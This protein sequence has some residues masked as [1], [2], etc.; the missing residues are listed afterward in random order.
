MAVLWRFAEFELDP[1]NHVLRRG[2]EPVKLA[3][4]PFKLLLLLV[5]RSGAL[6]RRDELRQALWPDG[7][8]VDFEHGLNTCMRQVRAA[9]GDDAEQPRIVETIP[10]VGYRLK[11]PVSRHRTRSYHPSLRTAGWAAGAL[12]AAVIAILILLEARTLL[13]RAAEPTESQTLYMRGRAS[14]DRRTNADTSTA[15]KLFTEAAQA[16]PAL[17]HAQAGIALSYLTHPTGL[18]G[19]AP[20][21]ARE[22]AADAA[23]RAA[24]ISTAPPVVGLAAAE[25]KLA[26]GEWNAAELEFQR[27]IKAAPR[28]AALHE[29]YAVALSLHGRLDEALREAHAARGLDPLSPRMITT[30]ASTLRFARRYEQAIDVAQE[31]LELDPTYGPAL[32]TLGLC[33]QALGQLDRAIEYYER[34][35]QPT[36]NLGHAYAV[37]GRTEDARRLLRLF[38]ARY[39]KQGAGAGAIA[40]IYVGLGDHDRAFEWLQRQVDAGAQ[41]TLR[42][43]EV[44]DPLRAD[45]RFERLFAQSGGTPAK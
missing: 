31:A 44:W 38:E 16:N 3:P 20:T 7:V 21:E 19:V 9:L 23:D 25:L 2:G 27:S 13:D 12:T 22:R 42:V 40:Q 17:A 30:L 41:T 24:A 10:R 35:G 45:P 28:D 43:A 18:A 34:E 15:R 32:H 5:T 29:A 26:R 1:D 39:E 4:Q 33:Y 14:L 6:V 36:G 8:S 11:V 37:A